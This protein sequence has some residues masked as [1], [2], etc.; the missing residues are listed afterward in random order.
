MGNIYSLS[1][2]KNVIIYTYDNFIIMR[3]IQA[4]SVT[5]GILLSNDYSSGFSSTIHNST[6]YYLYLNKQGSLIIKSI[7]DARNLYSKA[8]DQEL[9]MLEPSLISFKNYLLLF[10][11]IEN[12]IDNLF[13]LKISLPLEENKHIVC[14]EKFVVC[15]KIK[16]V[17]TPSLL[18]IIVQTS[19]EVYIYCLDSTLTLTQYKS[20]EAVKLMLE[21]KDST[22][23]K[24]MEENKCAINKITQAK[25]T[26]IKEKEQLITQISNQ[27]NELM[28]VA[29]QYKEEAKK[30][31]MRCH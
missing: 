30:W 7:I 14:K 3:T 11:V 27:Y 2:N 17:H 29:T 25:D 13:Y 23:N 5:N 9:T 19:K 15:P 22:I 24:I 20:S 8:S 21:V 28:N 1:V 10:F 18:F 12:P 31:Y 6:I 4:N 26:A 16:L